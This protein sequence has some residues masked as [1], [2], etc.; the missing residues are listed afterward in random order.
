[1][2][3]EYLNSRKLLVVYIVTS[4]PSASQMKQ[5]SFVEICCRSLLPWKVGREPRE[6]NRTIGVR[7]S[8]LNMGMSLRTKKVNISVVRRCAD[9]IAS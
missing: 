3:L 2:E 6:T 9:E 7:R 5:S 4:G 1:M 8:E